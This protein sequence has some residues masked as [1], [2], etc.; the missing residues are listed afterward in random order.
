LSARSTLTPL[1]LLLPLLSVC[2]LHRVAMLAIVG[3][4]FPEIFGKFAA[5]DIQSTHALEALEQ[6]ATAFWAQLIVLC[7]IVEVNQFRHYE[8]KNEFAFFDPLNLYPKDSA[9]QEK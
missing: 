5:D 4:A 6:A 7:G 9:G 3:W 8:D 2:V 1:P